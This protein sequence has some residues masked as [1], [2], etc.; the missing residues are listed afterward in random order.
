[1]LFVCTDCIVV[2]AKKPPVLYQKKPP[3]FVAKCTNPNPPPPPGNKVPK[4]TQNVTPPRFWHNLRG[5]YGG[6]FG[7]FWGGSQY[8]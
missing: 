2:R 5:L 4:K 7:T 8:N 3:L 6:F 1:M